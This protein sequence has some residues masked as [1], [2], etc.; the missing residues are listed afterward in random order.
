[1]HKG[2]HLGMSLLFHSFHQAQ[3]PLQSK[4]QMKIKIFNVKYK[5]NSEFKSKNLKKIP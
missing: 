4:I 5:K 2:Y 1:M 3:V